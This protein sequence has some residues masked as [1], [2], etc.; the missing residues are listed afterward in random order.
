MVALEES[1][2]PF[3]GL[4]TKFVFFRDFYGSLLQRI[5]KF[6]RVVLPGNPGVGKSVFAYYYLWRMIR[7]KDALPPDH[8]GNTKRPE[9][10]LS[11]L[12]AG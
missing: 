4:G 9:V 6:K 12:L 7:D 10:A 2:L 3:A 5:G 8:I 11:F 1:R